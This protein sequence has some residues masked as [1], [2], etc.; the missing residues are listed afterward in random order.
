MRGQAV[1]AVKALKSNPEVRDRVN[2]V[3]SRL[4]SAAGES[5]L[6]IDPRCK[7]VIGEKDLRLL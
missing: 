7:E 6:F 2:I 4:M 3:N 1:I 5:R